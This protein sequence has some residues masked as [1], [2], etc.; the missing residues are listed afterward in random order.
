MVAVMRQ[1]VVCQTVNTPQ[2]R[3]RRTIRKARSH[4]AALGDTHMADISACTP[5]LAESDTQNNTTSTPNA[6]SVADADKVINIQI[7]STQVEGEF[8]SANVDIQS[9]RVLNRRG[10]R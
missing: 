8:W 2:R 1:L 6:A 7:D 3:R 5:L 9:Y 10:P 4:S